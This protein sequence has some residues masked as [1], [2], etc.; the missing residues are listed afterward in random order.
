MGNAM[1][2][3]ERERVAGG[4]QVCSKVSKRIRDG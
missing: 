2:S 1:L 3:I 4:A